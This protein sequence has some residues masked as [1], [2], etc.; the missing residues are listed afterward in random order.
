M[1]REQDARRL[2]DAINRDDDWRAELA[3]QVVQLPGGHEIRGWV[4]KVR[5]AGK[6]AP[7]EPRIYTVDSPVEWSRLMLH[8]RM[9]VIAMGWT[10]SKPQ[11][12]QYRRLKGGQ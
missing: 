1:M 10:A 3:E 12:P 4:V 2:A 11:V 8:D 5:K 6:H 9:Q 7:Q